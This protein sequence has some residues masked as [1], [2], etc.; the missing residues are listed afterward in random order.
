[1]I[2]KGISL[3]ISV[4]KEGISMDRRVFEKIVAAQEEFCKKPEYQKILE[5]HERLH[6][7]FLQQVETMNPEQQS[8][9]W[10]YCGLLIEMHLHM[11]EIIAS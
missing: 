4:T 7:H 10:D 6:A 1:M 3:K 8:A 5:E 2:F 9:V 11:L